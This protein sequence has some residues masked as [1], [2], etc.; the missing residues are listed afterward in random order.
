M[1]LRRIYLLQAVRAGAYGFGS[2]ILGASLARGGLGSAQVGLVL[3]SLL[4]GSALA[5][6]GLARRA[7]RLGRRRVYAILY[8][9]MA[10]AGTVFA[11]TNALPA[12]IFAGLTGTLSV[13]V[14]ESGPFTSV[15]QAMIPEVAGARATRAFGRYNAIAALAGAGGS[16]LAGGPAALRDVLPSLPA[17]Q[18]WLLAY[19][20][21]GVCGV[22]LIRGLS[23]AVEA[24]QVEPAGRLR[25][26]TPIL[27]LAGLFAVDSF[28]GGFVVQ[29]FL[30]FWFTERYGASTALM[31]SVFAAAGL[32][33]A[34]SFIASSRIAARF[35]LLNTM[36]FTHF[37]SNVLL[38]LVPLAPSL[39][40]ALGL[41][42]LRFALSQ[43]DVPARQAYLAAI[44]G[45]AH[46]SEAAAVTNAV[47]TS[48][49]P[50][51]APLAAAAV[52]TSI[53]G[54]PFFI[55]GGLK[56]LYDVAVF[57][58]FRRIP[59]PDLEPS[60]DDAEPVE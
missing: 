34:G 12:L 43:M 56:A 31:G 22:A 25:V 48:A 23:P 4:A 2:V 33:Q 20:V 19:T 46:R 53:S 24:V 10:V 35:G 41:L 14:I 45:P 26:P 47:R 8:G 59:L 15:E 58:W 50:F 37:P 57:V 55:S 27:R 52:G 16:L 29:S 49:R 13:D 60:R 28:A 17:D 9:L 36:V 3:G 51:G 1:D 44:A 11:L 39:G 30:V 5:S 38:V 21:V 18:R 42:L 32:I 40:P 6:I 7:D 54:L